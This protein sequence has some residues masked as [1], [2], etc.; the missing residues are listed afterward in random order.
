M[1]IYKYIQYTTRR[2]NSNKQETY[3]HAH[4]QTYIHACIHTYIHAYLRTDRETDSQRQTDRQGG[5]QGGREAGR[6]AS[7]QTDLHACIHTYTQINHCVHHKKYICSMNMCIDTHAYIDMRPTPLNRQCP[8]PL[9]LH[10]APKTAKPF[11]RP[12]PCANHPP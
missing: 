2:H 12:Q 7:R 9:A 6:Q 5:R 10:P 11:I 8:T 1:Y 3:K 4:K